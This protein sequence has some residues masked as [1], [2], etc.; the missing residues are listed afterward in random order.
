[1]NRFLVEH[2]DYF[3]KEARS[4]STETGCQVSLRAGALWLL[5]LSAIKFVA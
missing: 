4:S 1:M 3:I 5:G 2:D